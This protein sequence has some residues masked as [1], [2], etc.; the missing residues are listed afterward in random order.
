MDIDDIDRKL[1]ALLQSDDRLALNDLSKKTG[2]AASTIND[3]IKRLVR[4]GV[5]T[6]FH[7][8]VAPESLGIDLLAFMLVGWSDARVEAPFL[9]KIRKSPAVLECHHVTGAW[10]YLLKV[11]IK[12]TRELETFLANVV[13][14]VKGVERTETLIA[15]STAKEIWALDVAR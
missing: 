1:L 4:N 12:N 7:A 6:G 8:R 2:V 14:G 15:L 10:N 11:R 5:I 13:K 3:R 9:D